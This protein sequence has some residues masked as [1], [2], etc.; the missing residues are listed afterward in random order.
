MAAKRQLTE[1]QAQIVEAALRIIAT[2]G[3]RRFTAQT[4]A[5]EVGLTGGALYR[6]FA[7]M[8]AVVGAVVERVGELLFEG[9]PPQDP[10][11]IERLRLFFLRRARTIH[12]NPLVS[13][14][15]LSDHLAQAG[16][17]TQAKR[18]GEFKKRSQ[19][20]VAECLTEARRRGALAPEVSP[21]A[22]TVV[23]LG[24]VLA[25]SHAAPAVPSPEEAEP[26]FEE[27]WACLE[28]TLRAPG[29]AGAAGKPARPSRGPKP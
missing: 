6:H 11:P 26:L 20:F 7:G 21:R 23:F 17:S 1:R 22:G 29:L 9:F 24:S 5:Q 3:S 4:L 27:V 19:A 10:D 8:D 2:E 25:L 28:H 18:L 12:G 15:L 13:R 14:L 16:G